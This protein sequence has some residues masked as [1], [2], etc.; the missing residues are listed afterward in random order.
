MSK[1]GGKLR[2]K[3]G[4]DCGMCAAGM[5]NAHRLKPVLLGSSAAGEFSGGVVGHEVP[6]Q[7]AAR[8]DGG[9]DTCKDTR[10]KFAMA[11]GKR[12]LDFF[13]GK[14]IVGVPGFGW[15]QRNGSCGGIDRV[16]INATTQ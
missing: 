3:C 11:G 5:R 8:R 9:R 16:G 4:V 6:D 10:C 13:G 15:R 2:D 7:N 12:I 14:A 1:S